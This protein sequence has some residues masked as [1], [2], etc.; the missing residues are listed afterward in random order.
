MKDE[1]MNDLQARFAGHEVDVDPGLWDA[2]SGQLAAGVGEGLQEALRG[3]FDGHE[4]VV[5]PQVWTS[6]SGQLGHGAAAGAGATGWLL[7]GLGAAAVVGGLAWWSFSGD[8][9]LNANVQPG[10]EQVAALPIRPIENTSG[11]ATQQDPAE[12]QRAP[13]PSSSAPRPVTP[14]QANSGREGERTVEEVL[15]ALVQHNAAEPHFPEQP[16]PVPAFAPEE[17]APSAGNE[18]GAGT[19]PERSEEQSHVEDAQRT[20]SPDQDDRG[21]SN[22][23]AANTEEPAE[24]ESVA[25]VPHVYIP[26]VFSPQGDGVNDR[27]K[28]VGRN[29]QKVSVRI[30]SART[31]AVV[32][33][34]NNLDDQWNGR[35][36]NNVP[37]EEGYYFYA[38]E[39][40]GL[41]GLTY[42]MGEVVRLFR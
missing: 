31:D 13:A 36:P 40:T 32:F 4:V 23:D 1:R 37:C 18:K 38:I 17:S 6:I 8:Q 19:P 12:E 14:G 16:E 28:V 2:I 21:T 26:N 33:R 42:P 35:D 41:N 5:D 15:G 20:A 39:V 3:K 27:L 30:I 7:G 24:E 10:N 29:Y 34:A 25:N 9:P 22:E 11:A